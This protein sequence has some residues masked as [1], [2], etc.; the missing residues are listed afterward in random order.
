MPR[1]EAGQS[2]LQ[3]HIVTVQVTPPT[4]PERLNISANANTNTNGTSPMKSSSTATENDSDSNTR[5]AAK[6]GRKATERILAKSKFFTERNVLIQNEEERVESLLDESNHSLANQILQLDPHSISL[7]K[8]LGK[9]GFC[10]VYE[11]D[12][13]NR[14]KAP[15]VSNDDSHHGTHASS[16]RSNADHTVPTTITSTDTSTAHREVGE[17]DHHSAGTD[18]AAHHDYCI[19]FLKTNVLLERKKFARGIADLSIEA[20]FLA[21][22]NH[23]HILKIRGVPTGFTLFEPSSPSFLA[24]LTSKPG[25][26]NGCFLLL[27]RLAMTLDTKINV[28]W[29]EAQIKWSSFFNRTVQDIRGS[30]RRV[31]RLE[32]I[33]VA[34]QLSQAMQ[35]LHQHNICYRD[36]KPDNIGFDIHDSLKLFDF[37]LA[38][39]LKDYKRHV[40]GT[41]QLTANTGSKR[42]MAPEVASRNRYNLS[43]DVFSFGILFW[44]ICSLEKPFDGFTELQHMN[45]VVQRGH[46]PR[47]DTIKNWPLSVRHIISRCWHPISNERPSFRQ[48]VNAL[49]QVQHD[50]TEAL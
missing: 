24:S 39:E 17:S 26:E 32:R 7:G 29:K 47:L 48:V 20:H 44:E 50:M 6:V 27:D 35:Y 5:Y 25:L 4:S 42:Y 1:Q 8:V 23:P 46:R 13:P 2:P 30:K 19:K 33:T 21:S 38:K 36:L 18:S 22:L 15:S 37:G 14:L 45:L 34:L 49:I 28:N 10:V 9:G 41:Y 16:G 3:D 43:V 12:I 31:F 40:D 11:A